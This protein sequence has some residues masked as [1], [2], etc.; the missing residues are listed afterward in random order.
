RLRVVQSLRT[1]FGTEFSV[2]HSNRFE[3]QL[4]Q[5]MRHERKGLEAL[6]SAQQASGGA[7]QPGLAIFQRRGARIRPLAE[8]L[9]LAS[10]R[11][12]LTTS[13]LDVAGSL[14]H[15]QAN[16][17]LPDEHRRHELI[18]YD[19]LTR[20]YRSSLARKRG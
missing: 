16:R 5:R 14:L 18:L 20:L 6:L 17:V 11:G 15:M 4:S 7:L 12:E 2:D 13:L 3:E 10:Q 19:F 8:E 1:S 9:R